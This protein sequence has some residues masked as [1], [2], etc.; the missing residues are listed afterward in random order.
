MS[1]A[2]CAKSC[3]PARPLEESHSPELY[4]TPLSAG[5]L[6]PCPPPSGAAGLPLPACSADNQRAPLLLP[7]FAGGATG[8]VIPCS[9]FAAAAPAPNPQLPATLP[10]ACPAGCT[11]L[12]APAVLLCE[13]KLPLECCWLAPDEPRACQ[14]TG[15]CTG[16]LPSIST[17]AGTPAAL[18]PCLLSAV[19]CSHGAAG[20]AVLVRSTGLIGAPTCCCTRSLTSLGCGPAAVC[21]GLL[22]GQ[23]GRQI[24]PAG[25]CNVSC[26]DPLRCCWWALGVSRRC[27][28][29]C[30]VEC[31]SLSAMLLWG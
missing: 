26:W 25:C 14:G 6:M 18:T 19:G 15:C 21:T 31:T 22:Q 12:A 23:S 10:A 13:Y 20:A 1:A 28:C 16:L 24:D 17:G 2:H 27:W 8:G 30:A 29:I 11:L 9:S 3:R 4:P 5:S 7:P